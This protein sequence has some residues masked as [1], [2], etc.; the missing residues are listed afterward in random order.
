MTTLLLISLPKRA[1]LKLT[2]HYS[3]QHC[4]L[5]CHSQERSDVA[6]SLDVDHV[7]PAES[8]LLHTYSHHT[9]LYKGITS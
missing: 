4:S 5:W 8:H 1:A 7:H 2:P 3:T 6:L 9:L